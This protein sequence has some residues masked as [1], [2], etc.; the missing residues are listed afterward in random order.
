[1]K[2]IPQKKSFC[3]D[4]YIIKSIYLTSISS[5]SKLFIVF[6]LFISSILLL[7]FNAFPVVFNHQQVPVKKVA[8]IAAKSAFPKTVKSKAKK[9][10]KSVI[11]KKDTLRD[12]DPASISSPLFNN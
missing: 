6:L 1:M 2:L 8:P 12:F 9:S 7:S 5:F 10:K 4:S 11:I 3:G